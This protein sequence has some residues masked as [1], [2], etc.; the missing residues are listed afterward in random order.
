MWAAVAEYGVV[1]E[2]S[3]AVQKEPPGGWGNRP[4]SRWCFSAL[5][6]LDFVSSGFGKMPGVRAVQRVGRKS[7]I[8]GG[9]HK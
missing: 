1:S 9:R 6:A 7:R 8:K 5:A 2:I 4:A 3:R